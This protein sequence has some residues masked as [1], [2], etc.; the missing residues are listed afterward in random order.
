MFV[1]FSLLLL[2]STYLESN[3]FSCFY[4]YLSSYIEKLQEINPPTSLQVLYSY[5]PCTC[6]NPPLLE[7]YQ[8][9]QADSNSSINTSSKKCLQDF[10]RVFSFPPCWRNKWDSQLAWKTNKAIISAQGQ[11]KQVLI[12]LMKIL[13]ALLPDSPPQKWWDNVQGGEATGITAMAG[14]V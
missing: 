9:L 7:A 1:L 4:L 5:F 3:M 2:A 6:R 10:L 8:P 13:L 12:M 11:S 14:T